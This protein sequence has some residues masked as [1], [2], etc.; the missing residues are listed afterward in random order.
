MSTQS[1]LQEVMR[2]LKRERLLIDEFADGKT[3]FLT[4]VGSVGSLHPGPWMAHRELILSLAL[5]NLTP[6]QR[7]S[8]ARAARVEHGREFGVGRLALET[9]S[10]GVPLGGSLVS[11]Q[12]R[13]GG[14]KALAC[15]AIGTQAQPVETDW[16]VV[17]AQPEWALEPPPRDLTSKGIETLVGL[18][19][20]VVIAVPSASAA[21]QVADELRPRVPHTAHPRFA[22]HLE[23]PAPQA[24]V[25][26]WPHDAYDSQLLAQRDI[27]SL[28]LIGANEAAHQLWQGFA[29]GRDKCEL[30]PAA[31][32]G[33]VDRGGFERFWI[34]CGKPK[35]LLQGDPIWVDLG[36]RFLSELGAT[37]VARGDGRQ[38]GL[39]G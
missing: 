39:F 36:E 10:S 23:S 25:C 14:L 16:L 21:R 18:G 20:S 28:V 1:E 33:R 6:A 2:M 13:G 17:R 4:H 31:C 35:I 15:W 38:L 11:L 29:D 9:R 26:I 12:T 27:H 8:L 30:V 3:T 24:P 37:V 32:P 5:A 7:A 19:G 34:G 22:P